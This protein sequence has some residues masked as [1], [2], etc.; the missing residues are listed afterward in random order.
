MPDVAA[1]PSS[2]PSPSPSSTAPTTS[3]SSASSTAAPAQGATTPSQSAQP[4][5]QSATPAPRTYKRTINGQTTEIPADDIDKAAKI[6]DLDPEEF[7]NV[8]QL[9][10]ASYQRFREAQDEKKRVEQAKAEQAKRLEDPRV[11]SLMQERGLSAEDAA[12]LVRVQEMIA[13]EQMT[14]EQR[15]LAEKERAI[16]EREAKIREAEEARQHQAMQAETAQ[17]VQRFNAEIP[18]A[19]EAAGLP[20]D[21][22]AARLVIEHAQRAA[23]LGM[24]I[25]LKWAARDVASQM[26]SKYAPVFA[27]MPPERLISALGKD[28]IDAIQKHL[29]SRA[30]PGIPQPKPVPQQANGTQPKRPYGMSVDEWREKFA[31]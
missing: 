29:I 23:S 4:G 24:P 18:A 6:L 7:L 22:A 10:A 14:P 16:N 5:T 1:A 31:R 30:Q 11:K 17:H 25:D 8:S 15:A 28:A 27:K 9:K 26:V 19:M 20:R 12:V 13:A 2:T 21:P 3:P